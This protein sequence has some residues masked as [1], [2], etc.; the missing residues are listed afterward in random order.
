MPF[1]SKAIA[2]LIIA[3]LAGT[4][5][6]SCITSDEAAAPLQLTDSCGQGPLQHLIGQDQSRLT[7]VQLPKPNR[8][9]TAN[10]IM[11]MDL[12]QDRLNI[13]INA[14]NKIEK[15]TCG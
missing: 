6:V 11:T 9:L 5:L 10:A 7:L 4:G 12:R 8:I 1:S 14:D 15:L 3:V 2:P 13:Y